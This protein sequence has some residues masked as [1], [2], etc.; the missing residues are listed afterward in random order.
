MLVVEVASYTQRTRYRFAGL[1][2]FRT[3]APLAIPGI[4]FETSVLF[5]VL[6]IGSL[7][8]LLNFYGTLWIIVIGSVVVFIPFASRIAIGNVVQIHSELEEAARV[9]GASWLAQM[10]E[11]F[12]PLFKNTTAIVWFYLLV[13]IIQLL[14]VPLMTYTS[15]TR[16]LPV[17]I[18]EIYYQQANVEFVSAV[19]TVFIGLLLLLLLL[20]RAFGV[21]FYELDRR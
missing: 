12:L 7:T 19:S 15:S 4:V 17:D 5:A 2:E 14:T 9:A 1:V 11:I 8:P 20:F 13:H 16:V 3:L 10:R 18:F 21:T 6:W